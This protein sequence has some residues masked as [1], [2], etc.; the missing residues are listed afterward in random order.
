M[1]ALLLLLNPAAAEGAGPC[2]AG[3]E[4]IFACPLEG[5]GDP[6]LAVC[7]TGTLTETSGDLQVRVGPVGA[8]TLVFPEAPAGKPFTFSR[9]TRPQT[10]YLALSFSEGGKTYTLRDESVGSESFRGLTIVEGDEERTLVCKAS[11]H[12]GTLFDLEGKVPAAS[13]GD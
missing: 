2:P 5:G 10:T 12:T 11:G 9:Y 4:V 1:I 13:D 6:V 7:A 8:P 3:A